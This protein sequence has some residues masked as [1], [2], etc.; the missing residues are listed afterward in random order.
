MLNE[1]FEYGF[2]RRFDDSHTVLGINIRPKNIDYSNQSPHL[3]QGGIYLST[4]FIKTD[5]VDPMHPHGFKVASSDPVIN[6]RK[7]CH[8]ISR[9]ARDSNHR[10][11]SNHYIDVPSTE[12]IIQSYQ[13]AVEIS[14]RI[15]TEFL[16]SYGNPGIK[17]IYKR[18]GGYEYEHRQM[19][20][21]NSGPQTVSAFDLGNDF[22]FVLGEVW[23][24]FDDAL[25]YYAIALPR[26]QFT[27]H[28]DP[29]Q[30]LMGHL[31]QGCTVIQKG[32]R[33]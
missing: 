30:S 27:V 29:A 22:H 1:Q 15:E 28:K 14:K 31:N 12:L 20:A 24:S 7:V 18:L 10:A 16:D 4:H 21:R 23:A 13:C 25:A 6:A 9:M 17:K 32:E 5:W 26:T 33:I 11:E 19:L 3:W 8:R 2:Y